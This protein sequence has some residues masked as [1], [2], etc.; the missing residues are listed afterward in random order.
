MGWLG[1]GTGDVDLVTNSNRAAVAEGVLE[2]PTRLDVIPKLVKSLKSSETHFCPN[3]ENLKPICRFRYTRC[4]VFDLTV[5]RPLPVVLAP[6]YRSQNSRTRT[7]RHHPV[8][9]LLNRA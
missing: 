2:F 3:I 9:V 4:P 6:A 5:S 7:K 1:A 8:D